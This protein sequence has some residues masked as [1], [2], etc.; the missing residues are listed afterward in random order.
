MFSLRLARHLNKSTGLIFGSGLRCISSFQVGDTA[1]LSKVFSA[2]D[3]R[4]FSELSLDYNPLH[5]DEEYAKTSRFGRC[6]VHGVLMNGLISGVLGTKLPG[7][8]SIFISQS[9]N[10]P[11]PLFVGEPVTAKVEILKIDRSRVTCS[12]VCIATERDKVVM[13]GTV[14]LFVPRRPSNS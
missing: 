12:T 3:V 1:E 14:E 6:V 7:N 2:E 9:I 13:D 5:L 4:T 11:A 10:F 8:G